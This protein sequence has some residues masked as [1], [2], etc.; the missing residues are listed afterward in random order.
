MPKIFRVLW[1]ALGRILFYLLL[2]ILTI[3]LRVGERSRVLVLKGQKVLV[4][5]GWLN[6]GQWS[7][8]GGGIRRMEQAD[9][10]AV[11][12]LKE[13]TGLDVTPS[14]LINLG[15]SRQDQR[16]ITFNYHR[17][18]CRINKESLLKKPHPEITD[19]AWIDMASL[20]KKNAQ[21]H[22]LSTIAAWRKKAWFAKI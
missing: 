21:E 11:R 9:L 18:M 3:Y 2:P 12:E 7:L 5:K 19:V 15:Q 8:P 22:V 17:F 1:V 10:A 13:E 4:V 6:N 20:N 16:F 14:E